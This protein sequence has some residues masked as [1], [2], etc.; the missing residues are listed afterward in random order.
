MCDFSLGRFG[1]RRLEKGGLFCWGVLSRRRVAQCG[2]ALWGA[3]GE[4]KS[5]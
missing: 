1:D 5:S 4:E 3:R 2:F